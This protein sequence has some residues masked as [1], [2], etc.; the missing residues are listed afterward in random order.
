MYAGG[1]FKY[2]RRGICSVKLSAQL[3]TYADSHNIQL[4]SYQIHHKLLLKLPLH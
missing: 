3:V 4:Y 2:I 1:K